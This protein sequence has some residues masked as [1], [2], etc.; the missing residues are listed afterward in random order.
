MTPL[1]GAILTIVDLFLGPQNFVS[2]EARMRA[3]MVMF[4]FLF[5]IFLNILLM[6]FCGAANFAL[7]RTL[8]GATVLNA[9]CAYLVR[10][11][12]D[13]EKVIIF[14][15]SV[16]IIYHGQQIMLSGNPQPIMMLNYATLVY[17]NCLIVGDIKKRIS[18]FGLIFAAT[19]FAFLC[20][21]RKGSEISLNA[22]SDD[23]FWSMNFIVS[24]SIAQV[25]ILGMALKVR[26]IAQAELTLEIEWQDRARR[27]EEVS[28]M[29]KAMRSLLRRPVEALQQDLKFFAKDCQ[30]TFPGDVQV[31]IDELVLISKAFGWI[32]RAHSG[33][34]LQS[35]VSNTF[36]RQLNI[37]LSAKVREEGWVL[38]AKHKGQPIEIYGPV[39]AIM[40]LIYSIIIQILREPQPSE[41][42]QLSLEFDYEE[43]RA[44]WRICWPFSIPDFGN[45]LFERSPSDP[46]Q[47][48][49]IEDLMQACNASIQHCRQQDGH[50]ILITGSWG[51]PASI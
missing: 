44:M 28:S 41:K 20:F 50:Q 46:K 2:A 10:K 51:Q 19:L 23:A 1:S 14:Y 35:I 3:R 15:S 37:L 7:L 13:P 8:V 11:S 6:I 30:R 47:Q 25:A 24:N 9:V 49:L 12:F 39:P 29:T 17:I 4:I 26:A 45:A 16:D 42:R 48:E 34:Q 36:M 32:Y 43:K 5:W 40:H 38:D 27:L 33:E 18:L 31:H 21:L 22:Q